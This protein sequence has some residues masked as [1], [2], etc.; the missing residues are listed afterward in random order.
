MMT[1]RSLVRGGSVGA[2][3]RGFVA[4]RRRV[5][6][7]S[8]RRRRSG[9]V[10]GGAAV[11]LRMSC[12]CR[13]LRQHHYR[14]QKR[15]KYE[16]FHITCPPCA[17]G[18]AFRG[19][20]LACETPACG[21]ATVHLPDLMHVTMLPALASAQGLTMFMNDA[22][23]AQLDR[24]VGFEPTGRGFE[25]LRARQ[26]LKD[27]EIP[28]FPDP[29]KHPQNPVVSGPIRRRSPPPLRCPE[30]IFLIV[31]QGDRYRPDFRA[32]RRT[33]ATPFGDRAKDPNS[34]Q[35]QLRHADP[36]MTPTPALIAS[37]C[38]MRRR[39]LSGLSGFEESPRAA[40][41]IQ[42]ASIPAESSSQA[43]AV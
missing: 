19:V 20:P 16:F 43:I 7:V 13:I 36:T 8:S 3:L 2:G 18:T 11:A 5:G 33:C 23:V 15:S 34:T 35:A 6:L 10:R 41:E 26:I 29:A 30:R 28:H 27:L 1:P 25:S 24:A 14:A 32:L 31:L 40:R 12:S 22:P 4:F 21:A 38:K 39:Y 17:L 37:G 42:S 9:L